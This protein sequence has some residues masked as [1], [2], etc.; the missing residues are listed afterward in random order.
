MTK[1]VAS[2]LAILTGLLICTSSFA[3]ETAKAE[4]GKHPIYSLKMKSLAGGD[5]DLSKYKGDVLLIVN[6]ASFCGATKQYADLQKLHK[7]YESRGLKVLGFPCNQFGKQEPKGEKEIQAFC[8]KNYGVEFDMFSKILVNEEKNG[9]NED[10]KQADLYKYLTSK[11]AYSA[12]PGEIRWNF[13][14]F[15]VSRDGK[16]VGRYRTSIKPD[17]PEVIKAIEAE[18]QKEAPKAKEV[19]AEKKEEK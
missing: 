10:A 12:D 16:V 8:Q 11:D 14:K 5:V 1:S 13:E 17:S 15:L 6:T 3:D 2:S 18:I 7:T 9:G 19:V 4:K